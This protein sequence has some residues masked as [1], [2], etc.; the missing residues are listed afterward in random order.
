MASW[1]STAHLDLEEGKVA[2]KFEEGRQ[3]SPCKRIKRLWGHESKKRSFK[4][5]RV[6]SQ[7]PIYRYAIFVKD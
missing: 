5:K 7:Y 2:R 3:G 1:S 4:K 6:V